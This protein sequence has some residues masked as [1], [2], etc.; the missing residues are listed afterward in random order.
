MSESQSGNSERLRSSEI[1]RA[2]Q[3]VGVALTI[4]SATKLTFTLLSIGPAP[5]VQRILEFYSIVVHAILD[6]LLPL[7][8]LI[9]WEA[10]RHGIESFV[11]LPYWRDVIALYLLIGAVNFRSLGI[12]S[13]SLREMVGEGTLFQ[14]SLSAFLAMGLIAVLSVAWPLS[15][16]LALGFRTRLYFMPFLRNAVIVLGGVTLVILGNAG[17]TAS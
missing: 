9:A 16:V 5:V 10:L 15:I 7:V 12:T 14:R 2:S 6:P 8:H 1:W 3:L 17:L 4:V 11:A 13:D